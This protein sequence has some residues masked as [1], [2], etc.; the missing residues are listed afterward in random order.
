M[1]PKLNQ[2]SADTGLIPSDV[3]AELLPSTDLV[4]EVADA[5]SL[6]SSNT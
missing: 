4:G 5:T 2:G 3:V 6:L 1:I